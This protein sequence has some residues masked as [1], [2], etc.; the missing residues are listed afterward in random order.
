[1]IIDQLI[2]SDLNC[3][4]RDSCMFY[5]DDKNRINFHLYTFIQDKNE[6]K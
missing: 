6:N 4:I 5:Y 1:M 3:D 2:S